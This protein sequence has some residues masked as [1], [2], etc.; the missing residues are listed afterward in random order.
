MI[1]MRTTLSPAKS[2]LIT[3]SL[4]QI[5]FLP[6]LLNDGQ[7]KMADEIMIPIYPSIV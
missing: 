3:A 4:P 6:K 1:S 2:L 7:A 5:I